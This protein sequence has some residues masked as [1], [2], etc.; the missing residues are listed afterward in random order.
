MATREEFN[1]KLTDLATQAEKVKQEVLD[2]LGELGNT[3]TTPEQDALLT[4]IGAAVGDLGCAQG[5]CAH[6][7]SDR[8]HDSHHLVQSTPG[9]TIRAACLRDGY[10]WE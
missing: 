9:G 3:D 5:R 8:S 2:A 7:A 10:G 1:Q 4:R 6:H